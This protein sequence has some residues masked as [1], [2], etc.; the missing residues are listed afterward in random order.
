ASVA[1]SIMKRIP[2][3][4][5][6]VLTLSHGAARADDV[7]LH[8]DLAPQS[9]Y[10]IVTATVGDMPGRFLIDT[11]NTDRFWLDPSFV[12]K[13]RPGE[14]RPGPPLICTSVTFGDKLR[15]ENVKAVAAS[16]QNMS[17][18]S[19]GIQIDGV[20]PVTMFARCKLDLDFPARRVRISW[21]AD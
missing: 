15:F 18:L 11:G 21:N 12:R 3:A 9:F 20:L 10:P 7:E 5:I 16:T 8:L 4:I 6:V 2:L 1:T 14:Y 17:R 19:G 13:L